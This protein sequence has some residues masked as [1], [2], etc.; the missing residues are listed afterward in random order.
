MDIKKV[1]DALK[2]RAIELTA[3]QL[4]QVAGG[5]MTSADIDSCNFVVDWLR[6]FNQTPQELR[7][8]YFASF[9]D[10]DRQEFC[11]MF[12]CPV[13]EVFDYLNTNM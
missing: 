4:D 7:E 11:S 1:T 9:N 3:E 2:D 8:A 12:S 13:E 10:K 6:T 5:V